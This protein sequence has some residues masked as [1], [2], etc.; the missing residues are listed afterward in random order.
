MRLKKRVFV[1]YLGERNILVKGGYRKGSQDVFLP[2]LGPDNWMDD[3]MVLLVRGWG[4]KREGRQARTHQKVN[5]AR[6]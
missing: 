5:L 6:I 3:R 2:R 1:G 4:Y